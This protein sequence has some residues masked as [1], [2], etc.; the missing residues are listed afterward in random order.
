MIINDKMST[1]Q[2]ETV[3]GIRDVKLLGVGN[4]LINRTRELS[5]QKNRASMDNTK[6]RQWYWNARRISSRFTCEKV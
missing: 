2:N 5:L 6:V 4:N 3:R 1:Q